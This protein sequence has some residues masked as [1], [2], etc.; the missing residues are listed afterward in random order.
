MLNAVVA[1]PLMRM[2]ETLYDFK[3]NHTCFLSDDRKNYI[4]SICVFKELFENILDLN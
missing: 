2:K 1:I 3:R 4:A